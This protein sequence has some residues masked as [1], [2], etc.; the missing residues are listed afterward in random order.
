ML[1][2]EKFYRKWIVIVLSQSR[3]YVY[4]MFQLR[5][6]LFRSLDTLTALMFLSY[7]RMFAICTILYIFCLEGLI[8]LNAAEN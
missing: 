7:F 6:I 2:M 3:V 4:S 8:H 5:N 1:Y